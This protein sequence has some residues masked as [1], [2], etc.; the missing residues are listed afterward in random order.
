VTC[1]DHWGGVALSFPLL[2]T[3]AVPYWGVILVV[4]LR[5]LWIVTLSSSY[6]T[7][8]ALALKPLP[9]IFIT[10]TYS[11]S[12]LFIAALLTLSASD[13]SSLTIT[14]VY[15]IIT[16]AVESIKT[17]ISNIYNEVL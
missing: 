3:L 16:S 11:P 10:I 17:S 7:C 8:S 5:V 15:T 9:P 1:R 13:S 12:M 4:T 14:I 2:V 6:S